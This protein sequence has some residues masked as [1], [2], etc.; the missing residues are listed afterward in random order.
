[1]YQNVID[2]DDVIQNKLNKDLYEVESFSYQE[3]TVF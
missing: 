3:N 1:M 2:G